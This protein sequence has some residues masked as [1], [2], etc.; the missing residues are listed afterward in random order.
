[1]MAENSDWS[2]SDLWPN[3]VIFGLGVLPF[4]LNP[5]IYDLWVYEFVARV[6]DWL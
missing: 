4:F 6:I 3:G 1:M 5:L 2:I